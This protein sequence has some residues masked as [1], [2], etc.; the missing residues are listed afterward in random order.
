MAFMWLSARK[1]VTIALGLIVV[2]FVWPIFAPRT[3]TETIQVTAID[4]G[5]GLAARSAP[6]LLRLWLFR[7]GLGLRWLRAGLG[8]RR[9]LA[10]LRIG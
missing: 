3:R 1:T 7:A 8:P 10:G 2:L 9:F 6:M 4:G 5:A